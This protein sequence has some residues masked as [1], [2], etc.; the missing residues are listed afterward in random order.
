MK[1]RR[2]RRRRGFTLLEV[3][4]V[5]AIL[6]VMG[7]TVTYYFVGAQQKANTR[8]AQ[9]QIGMFEDM[10]TAYH[11]DVGSY[12]TTQQGLTALREAPAELANTTKW[13]GPYVEKS[14]PPDPWGNPYQYEVAGTEVHIWSWGADQQDNTEDDVHNLT[15]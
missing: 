5:L 4:L 3:L 7:S 1:R 2:N 12:P 9:T 13:Q 6:V 11:M 8:Q 15:Q 10:L 14:I